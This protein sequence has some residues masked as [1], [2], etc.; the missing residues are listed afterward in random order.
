MLENGAIL[1]VRGLELAYGRTRVL[2]IRELDVNGPRGTIIGLGGPNG[3]GKSTFLKAGLG[4]HAAVAG[5]IRI[6]GSGPGDR[7]FRS[8]LSRIGYVPQARPAGALR[9]SVGEV[10]E[11]GRYGRIGF[12]RPRSAADRSAV[13]AAMERTGV[14]ALARRAV[15][16]LS[17]GQY[18]R[19]QIARALAAEPELMLLDEPGSHLDAEGRAGVVG[20]LSELARERKAS[21]LLVSHDDDLLKL[22]DVTI[23]FEGGKA[24]LRHA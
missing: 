23:A 3:A 18:Q 4:L 15:Q 16:E 19:V 21:M 17:G 7:D 9:L 8:V 12:L 2:S 6:L 13:R 24:E 1:S 20:L 14:A 10:V 11:S 22:A 5:T